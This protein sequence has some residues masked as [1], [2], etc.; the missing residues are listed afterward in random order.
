MNKINN[1]N[2]TIP[3]QINN[4]N[5]VVVNMDQKQQASNVNKVDVK[6]KK[7]RFKYSIKDKSGKVVNGYFDAYS[8]IDVHSFL[9]AQGYEVVSIEEDKLSTKLGIASLAPRKKMKAKELTFFLTQLSTYI[10]AGI[11]L[12]EA[13]AILSRQTKKM[14]DKYLYQRIVFELNIHMLL[15]HKL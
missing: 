13:V 8:K 3:N 14:K 1:N 12:V 7:I 4:Q 9:L 10:K 15:F 5:Q 2:Q 11:P 6:D